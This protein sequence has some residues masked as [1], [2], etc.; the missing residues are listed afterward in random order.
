MKPTGIV[1]DSH[2]SIGAGEARRLG[3]R[4][5]PMPFYIDN[6]CFYENVTLTRQEF[7]RLLDSGARITTSQPAPAE[8]M[9]NWDQALE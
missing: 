2:S 3:V 4:V 8:V 9:E 5:L 1:T 6:E 7:F